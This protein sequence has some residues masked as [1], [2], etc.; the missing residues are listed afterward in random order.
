MATKIVTEHGL[1]QEIM[2]VYKTTYPTVREALSGSDSTR[3]RRDIRA[4]ALAH[5]GAEVPA[6]RWEKTDARTWVRKH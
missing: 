6:V 5:G 2:T 3:L 1:R 4:Y